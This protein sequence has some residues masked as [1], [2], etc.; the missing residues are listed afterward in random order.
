[1]NNSTDGDSV[2]ANREVEEI[3]SLDAD[4]AELNQSLSN[5]KTIAMKLGERGQRRHEMND[6][7][8][9]IGAL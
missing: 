7:E 2:A 8:S 6:I 1:M 3:N 4:F 5:L 9:A